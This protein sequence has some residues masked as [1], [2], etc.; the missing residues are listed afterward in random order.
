MI[1]KLFDLFYE[2]FGETDIQMIIMAKMCNNNRMIQ[3]TLRGEPEQIRSWLSE[4]NGEV[5]HIEIRK[6]YDTLSIM[7]LGVPYAGEVYKVERNSFALETEHL[8]YE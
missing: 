1:Y 8:G 5:V 6:L 7:S 4:V 2:Q 3:Y